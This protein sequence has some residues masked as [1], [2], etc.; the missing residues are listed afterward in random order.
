VAEEALVAADVLKDVF[1]ASCRR[2]CATHSPRFALPRN[3]CNRPS[4]NRLSLKKRRLSL[5]ARSL[6][7]HPCRTA[8]GARRGGTGTMTNQFIA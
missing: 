5:L 6:D 8:R 2:S 3:C 7:T 1:L 4:C